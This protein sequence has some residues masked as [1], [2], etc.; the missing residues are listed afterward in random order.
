MQLCTIQLCTRSIVPTASAFI[1]RMTG[2]VLVTTASKSLHRTV[3]SPFTSGK[4]LRILLEFLILP[5]IE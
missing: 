2:H 5:A 1:S 3:G 4:I